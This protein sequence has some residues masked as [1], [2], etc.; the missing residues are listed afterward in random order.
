MNEE[1]EGYCTRCHIVAKLSPL[2][3]RQGTVWICLPCRWRLVAYMAANAGITFDE[4][5]SA[6]SKITRCQHE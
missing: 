3:I 2:R 1:R 4:I 6:L 5:S